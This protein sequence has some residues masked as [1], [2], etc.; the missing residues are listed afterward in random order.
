MHLVCLRADI[1][2]VGRF[3]HLLITVPLFQDS[4]SRGTSGIERA[5]RACLIWHAERN[6]IQD[7]KEKQAMTFNSYTLRAS[8]ILIGEV[9]MR[10]RI[11]AIVL[12]LLQKVRQCVCVPL[13][14]AKTG[15]NKDLT[16]YFQEYEALLRRSPTLSFGVRR[17]SNPHVPFEILSSEA[18]QIIRAGLPI[19]P[20]F[21]NYRAHI[22]ECT[23]CSSTLA[24]LLRET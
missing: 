16:R 1:G 15:K 3:P 10:S 22:E 12:F 6:I 9:V 7:G 18:I 17:Y 19:G 5:V 2:G 13:R 8:R 24:S 11:L 21:E 4:C 14:S 23:F 20:P